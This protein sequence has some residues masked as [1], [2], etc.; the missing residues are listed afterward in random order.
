MLGCEETPALTPEPPIFSV[1]N[2]AIITDELTKRPQRERDYA[3]EN[4]ALVALA[5]KMAS[6]PGSILQKLAEI[7]LDLCQAHSAGV[8]LL[9]KHGDEEVVRFQAVAGRWSGMAGYT[10][11]RATSPSEEVVKSGHAILFR[12]PEKHYTYSAKLEPAIV[13]ALLIPLRG[14]GE[15]VGTIWVISHD[16]QR[17]FDAE[18]ARLMETL[19]KF[20]SSA[21][22]LISS[23]SQLSQ[24]TEERSRAEAKSVEANAKFK[25]V[26][27]QSS[28]FAGILSPDG[29]MLEVNHL[30]L[31]V[32]GFTLPDVKEKLFWET[33]WWQENRWVQ[34]AL[35]D[36]IKQAAEGRPYTAELPYVWADGSRHIVEIAIYPV[37]GSGGEVICLHATGVD[38]TE[39]KRI[40]RQAGELNREL[41]RQSRIFE[42]LLSS[43]SD[44]V[45]LYDGDGRIVYANRQLLKLWGL[46][47]ELATGIT[48][49]ELKYPAD[50]IATLKEHIRQV[51]RTGKPLRSETGYTS[52]TGQR[53][54]YEYIFNPV[55]DKDGNVELI[56]GTTREIGERKQM[57]KEL[58][59]SEERY[60]LLA[61]ALETQVQFRTQELRRK[62]EEISRQAEQIR[63]L[64]R[65]LLQT[66]DDERRHVARELHDSAGQTLVVLTL[67]LAQLMESA[68]KNAPHLADALAEA[69]Q[70]SQQLTR[71]IRT[72]SY[73]LH[74]PLLDESGLRAA[75]QWYVQGLVE[76]SGMDIQLDLAENM[77]RSDQE[78]ELV[79]FRVIQESLTNVHR[80]SG[81]NSAMV[82]L[83]QEGEKFV[84][85][86]QDQGK[87]MS[88]DRLTEI[89]TRGHGLGIRG[90][91][92]RVRQFNGE[93]SVDSG[94]SGTRISVS[95]PAP[96]TMAPPR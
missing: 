86:V 49:E 33:P 32:T 77:D 69:E 45:Y 17:R 7:S 84:V 20:A 89:Q 80:H 64:S 3:R 35:R 6:D 87:G 38:V 83:R 62:H 16:E 82:R 93:L 42:T 30:C 48:M 5:E 81:S 67:Q 2:P 39:R 51:F 34:Q 90:M 44:F 37:R 68:K 11:P 41:E 75:I 10:L 70:A 78:V 43:I 22:Q 27:E 23:L 31:E 40:E 66:Q 94:G 25:A 56:A 71:E 14:D 55:F 24:Q 96:K 21:Y 95:I 12:H 58:R 15:M 88:A 63:E 54:Y 72:A 19:A 47:A 13:E 36:G 60:R 59:E 26:F 79:V 85:E 61:N 65:I 76:R 74:P 28:N 52:P 92:E 53:G 91:R 57:E 18:D 29:T 9:E 46:P 1:R 50:L 8:S 4:R 73:L